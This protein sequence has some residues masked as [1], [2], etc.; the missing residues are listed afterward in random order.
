MLAL[1]SYV[2]VFTP[3]FNDQ[4]KAIMLHNGTYSNEVIDQQFILIN[5]SLDYL[6]RSKEPWAQKQ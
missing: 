5:A 4:M 1:T 6:N 3:E 2:N